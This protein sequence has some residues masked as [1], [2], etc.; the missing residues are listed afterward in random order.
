M[1]SL[2]IEEG[3]KPT[4]LEKGLHSH[5]ETSMH[6]EEHDFDLV[7]LEASEEH[8]NLERIIRYK[9]YQIK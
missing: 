1:F 7:D 9:D 8:E 6:D 5:Q 4:S 2:Q 3:A